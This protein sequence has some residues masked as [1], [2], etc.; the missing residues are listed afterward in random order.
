MA[1]YDP[2]KDPRLAGLGMGNEEITARES[3]GTQEIAEREAFG[4]ARY[5]KV[6]RMN[7]ARFDVITLHAQ[8][9]A[10]VFDS[11]ATFVRCASACAIAG[12]IAVIVWLFV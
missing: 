6:M 2:T 8:A 9:R 7:D 3:M 1:E 4:N 12:T 11:V 10:D 5:D